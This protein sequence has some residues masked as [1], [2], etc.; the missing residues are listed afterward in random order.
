MHEFTTQLQSC[1]HAY[2]MYKCASLP[3]EHTSH[4]FHIYL[5]S[6]Y[7]RKEIRS[8]LILL[9]PVTSVVILPSVIVSTFQVTFA[10]LSVS[11]PTLQVVF[12]ISF[13]AVV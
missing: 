5:Q 10:T 12:R 1:V 8:V 7:T 13:T 4:V 9:V 2:Y 3:S 6:I 11:L